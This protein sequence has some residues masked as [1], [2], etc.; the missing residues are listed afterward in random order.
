MLNRKQKILG[1]NIWDVFGEA[2][3]LAFYAH[4][5]IAME[6]AIP[7]H[8]EEFFPPFNSWFDV[9]VYPTDSG[10]CVYF[11]NITDKKTRMLTSGAAVADA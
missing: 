3:S 2:R 1:K 10:L 8:Y 9:N 5:N 4:N 11:K 6:Q 7:V